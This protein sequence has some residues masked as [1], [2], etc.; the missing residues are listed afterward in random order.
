MP[1]LLGSEFF[2]HFMVVILSWLLTRKGQAVE[3]MGS[4]VQR[5]CGVSPSSIT[6]QERGLLLRFPVTLWGW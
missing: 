5:A 4:G 1:L 3:S 6:S 2:P